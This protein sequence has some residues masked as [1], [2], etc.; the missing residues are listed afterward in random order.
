M[1]GA[2]PAERLGRPPR[3][4]LAGDAVALTGTD[5][6]A[7]TATLPWVRGSTVR[8][9][10]AGVVDR[11]LRSAREQLGMEVAY[12][13]EF[14]D[15]HQVFRG[16]DGDGRPLG[17]GSD[18]SVPLE[19]TYCQR[20]LRGEIPSAVQDSLGEPGL[21]GLAARATFR[22][23]VGVP[24]RFSDGRLYG[25]LCG[26]SREPCP[27][28]NPRDVRF[29]QVLADLLAEHLE[30]RQR[31]TAERELQLRRLDRVREDG[32]LEVVFQPIVDLAS[33]QPLAY[34][35]LA[36]FRGRPLRPPEAWF[37]EAETVGV[38]A[39][40]ELL[41]VAEAIRSLERL[42]AGVFLAVNVSPETV[43]L[44]AFARL[45][46]P[47]AERLIVEVTE[48]AAVRDYQAIQAATAALRAR[49][50]RLAVDDT[51]AGYASLRHILRLRPDI[52]KLDMSLTRGIDQDRATAAMTSAL[53]TFGEQT[54]AI[55]TAEG[56]ETAGELRHLRS[57]GLRY[58]QGYLLGRPR[59]LPA[60]ASR[61]R[62]PMCAE[63]GGA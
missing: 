31:A 27:T 7:S 47:C 52:I 45:V 50:L 14:R 32:E 57:L 26:A 54:G 34:E 39:E 2:D 15:G 3:P 60:R 48:H 6:H 51:G 24:I 10:D 63:P 40:L 44:S 53:V 35:A 38:G 11:V 16:V 62:V 19:D 36:R 21:A 28:L 55:V 17:V 49:G 56:I 8:D 13:S 43:A 22:A 12:Y 37:R 1:R 41:A 30:G 9:G 58:G 23:Y 42:P 20:M 25:T 5:R 4:Y 46:T 33:L 18:G 29:L 61:R 59:T